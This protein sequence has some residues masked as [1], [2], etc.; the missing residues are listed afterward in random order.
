MESGRIVIEKRH[1]IARITISN[2]EKLNALNLEMI[3]TFRDILFELSND[4]DIDIVVITGEGDR[5]FSVGADIANFEQLNSVKGY[6]L[7]KLGYE[8][9]G[10]MSRM[11]QIFIAVVK[12]YCLAGGFEVALACDFI[13]ASEDAT[14]ALPEI[15]LGIMPGWG[16]DN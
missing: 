13:I 2:T 3:Q 5:C 15:G 16:G 11:E 4:E 6:K 9:H 10:Q 12:G 7:M 8:V 1:R 14:F